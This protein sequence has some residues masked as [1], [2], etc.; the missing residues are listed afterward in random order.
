MG[1]G[2]IALYVCYPSND[3]LLAATAVVCLHSKFTLQPTQVT[4]YTPS[5][6]TSQTIHGHYITLQTHLT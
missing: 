4:L 1:Q 3:K 6:A 5:E 2:T